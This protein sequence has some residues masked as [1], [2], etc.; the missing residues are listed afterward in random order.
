MP[1][2]A[3]AVGHWSRS[4]L[5]DRSNCDEQ[6]GLLSLSFGRIDMKSAGRRASGVVMNYSAVL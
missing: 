4:H 1:S 2:Y 5:A 3:P 6:S